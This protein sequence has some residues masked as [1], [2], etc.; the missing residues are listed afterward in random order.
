MGV[1]LAVTLRRE[2]LILEGSLPWLGVGNG[3]VGIACNHATVLC[4][5]VT[6]G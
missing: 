5:S 6:D 2:H 4:D 1:C 3:G